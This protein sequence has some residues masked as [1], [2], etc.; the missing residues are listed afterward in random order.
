MR[1]TS[2]L[3]SQLRQILIQIM[4]PSEVSGISVR[5]GKVYCIHDGLAA[6]RRSLTN[7]HPNIILQAFLD[8]LEEVP[9]R[10]GFKL[11]AVLNSVPEGWPS[12]DPSQLTAVED[13]DVTFVA[14]PDWTREEQHHIA[15]IRYSPR[16]RTPPPPSSAS[17]GK[18]RR[19]YESSGN[20]SPRPVSKKVK[21]DGEGIW[22]YL[23]IKNGSD[24]D[25]DAEQ[26]DDT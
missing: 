12:Y 13:M 26:E 4:R 23:S 22:R 5:A 15:T 9:G 14:C 1:R 10:K 8:A 16:A 17:N 21:I 19:D 3:P 20:Q 25:N 6:K 2:Y 24:E 18:R 11:V 7:D